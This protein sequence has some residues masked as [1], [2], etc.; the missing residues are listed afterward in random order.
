MYTLDEFLLLPEI[1]FPPAS[2]FYFLTPD[3]QIAWYAARDYWNVLHKKLKSGYFQES[4]KI[5]YGINPVA[6]KLSTAQAN[7]YLAFYEVIRLGWDEIARDLLDP[8]LS[9]K[10]PESLFVSYL[11]YECL[12][13]FSENINDFSFSPQ[14]WNK[15]PKKYLEK[16]PI[17][18]REYYESNSTL[19]KF[20]ENLKGSEINKAIKNYKILAAERFSLSK[21]F[22]HRSR[23]AIKGFQMK[24]G[25]YIPSKKNKVHKSKSPKKPPAIASWKAAFEG[26]RKFCEKCG[27]RRKVDEDMVC[28]PCFNDS[29]KWRIQNHPNVHDYSDHYEIMIINPPE[30]D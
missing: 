13:R 8:K 16:A 22:T 25:C 10:S 9:V 21:K 11:F 19:L 2:L 24:D 14:L 6:D 23:G 27:K 20:I 26:K 1:N 15:D 4:E 5:V 3:Q 18:G 30:P 12:I 29:E 28:K 7:E 17:G